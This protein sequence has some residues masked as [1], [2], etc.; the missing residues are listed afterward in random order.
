M[1][2]QETE[3]G[4]NSELLEL[5]DDTAIAW[6]TTVDDPE[7]LECPTYEW[8]EKWLKAR[9]FKVEEKPEGGHRVWA[10]NGERADDDEEEGD[11]EDEDGD[12]DEG[13]EE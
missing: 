12:D 4:L 2:K 10:P 1:T 11:E 3:N 6:L 13:E 7:D 5:S 9:G 8:A